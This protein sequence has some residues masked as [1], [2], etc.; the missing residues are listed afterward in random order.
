MKLCG[1]VSESQGCSLPCREW[2]LQLRRAHTADI[3]LLN[4]HYTT[5]LLDGSTMPCPTKT[6]ISR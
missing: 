3:R 2:R 4:M 5:H 1:I 6:G